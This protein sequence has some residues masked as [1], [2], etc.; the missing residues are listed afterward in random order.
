VGDSP[1]TVTELLQAIADGR[2]DAEADLFPIVYGEL[3]Q[4]AR[5]LMRR[6]AGNH[7]LQT[8][9]LVHEAYLRLARPELPN[10]K[11][12]AHFF[13][14]AAT[15]M[16]RV[17]VD[18]ARA[19]RAAKRGWRDQVPLDDNGLAVNLDEPD[20][21]LVIDAALNRLSQ[22]DARQGR[23]VELRFFAGMTVDET[24][25]VLQISTRTVKREWQLARAWLYGE[26]QSSESSPHGPAE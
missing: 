18:Y 8:T 2:K 1:D 25:E 16:R 12:R 26:L 10:F 11:N 22:L 23:I 19:R 13:A 4:I 6:E 5:R 7:T 15:V 21:V 17:L 9:A 24:A 3:R 20:M 14:V